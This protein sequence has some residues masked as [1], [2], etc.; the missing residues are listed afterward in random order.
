MYF[1]SVLKNIILFRSYY[2][3]TDSEADGETEIGLDQITSGNTIFNLNHYLC[4]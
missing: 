3:V 2:S 4:A 1:A